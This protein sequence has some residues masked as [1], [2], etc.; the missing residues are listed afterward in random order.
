MPNCYAFLFKYYAHKYTAIQVRLAGQA[1]FQL[2]N[3]Y[4]PR[5]TEPVVV[6]TSVELTLLPFSFF[7]TF[8]WN[9]L[10]EIYFKH[11]LTREHLLRIGCLNTLKLRFE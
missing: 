5:F 7:T 10:R 3:K 4:N 11:V 1:P 2:C 9:D 8:P 6:T